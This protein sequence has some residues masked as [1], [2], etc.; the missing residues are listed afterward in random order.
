MTGAAQNYYNCGVCGD[1]INSVNFQNAAA[2]FY[3]L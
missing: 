3:F 1:T 2:Y